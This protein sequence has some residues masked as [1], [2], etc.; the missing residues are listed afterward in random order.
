MGIFNKN[1]DSKKKKAGKAALKPIN[2]PPKIL[3]A[4]GEVISGNSKIRTWMMDN[5]YPELGIF[6]HALRNDVKAK[7]WLM[8]NGYPHL[9]A[10][11]S[12][13]EGD[14]IALKWLQ[15]FNFTL[16]RNMALAIDGHKEAKQWLLQHDKLYAGLAMKMERVKNDIDLKNNSPHTINP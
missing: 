9:L 7:D 14:Q 10:M 15:Q 12:G 5:G 6:Y 2:Y 3:L 1:K 13:G 4:W 11:I 16:L 8:N